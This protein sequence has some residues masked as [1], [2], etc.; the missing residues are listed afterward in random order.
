MSTNHKTVK[1]A[2]ATIALVWG[3]ACRMD[4]QD[5]ATPTRTQSAPPA[6][7][8]PLST[9]RLDALQKYDLNGNGELDVAEKEQME[10]ERKARVVALKARIN[11]P[12]DRNG[13]GVLEPNEEQTMQADRDKLSAFKG[14]AL[15]RYDANHDGVLDPAERQRMVTERQAFLKDV[16][17]NLLAK[18]DTNRDGKLDPQER[19]VMDHQ[20]AP[21]TAP[22]K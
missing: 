8:G 15:R 6:K 9:A 13:N 18:F 10:S 21:R 4:T 19:A 1:F 7:V 20:I 22:T 17:G 3:A 11:A 5:A 2:I 14:A 12:Y 16:K